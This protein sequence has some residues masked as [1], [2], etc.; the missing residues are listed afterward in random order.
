MTQLEQTINELKHKLTDV[1]NQLKLNQLEQDKLQKFDEFLSS[2]HFHE[3]FSF[4]SINK[5]TMNQSN[6]KTK[7]MEELQ[8]RVIVN[9]D[10]DCFLNLFTEWKSFLG[11][12]INRFDTSSNQCD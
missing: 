3:S 5:E 1:E 7:E 8:K 9:I 4:F 6:K 10:L 11:I 12:G 2:Y